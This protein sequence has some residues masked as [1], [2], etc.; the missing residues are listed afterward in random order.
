MVLLI[1]KKLRENG[2]GIVKVGQID[3]FQGQETAVVI[4]ST[5]VDEPFVKN[6]RTSL[7][8]RELLGCAKR[9]NVAISRAIALLVVCGNPRALLASGDPKYKTL[10][11][12][13]ARNG[14]YI[15]CSCP[16]ADVARASYKS[17]HPKLCIRP[18]GVHAP[19]GTPPPKDDQDALN[20]ELHGDILGSGELDS[21][22]PS[23]P[24]L[25]E[26]TPRLF[27]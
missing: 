5:V 26:L 19:I 11:E 24:L 22:Y 13:C 6:A 7:L 4:L 20:V 27:C 21:M 12:H 16:E 8:F 18:V 23:E 25:S 17:K 10:L 1:R 9:F 15:G 2:Y 3:D 14:A